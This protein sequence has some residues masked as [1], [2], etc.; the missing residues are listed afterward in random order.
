MTRKFKFGPIASVLGAILSSVVIA[1]G[2]QTPNRRSRAAIYDPGTEVTVNGTV[3]AV[4]T[5]E[6]R[7]GFAGTHLTLKSN[8]AVYDVHLGPSS[9]IEEKGFSFKNGDQV[10]V[11]G[12]KLKFDGVDSIIARQLKTSTGTLTLRNDKGIPLW[13]RGRRP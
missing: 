2:Q 11:T 10:E 4:K 1:F 8:D 3:Q 13:S 6:G 12:S 7:R 5:V 9:F